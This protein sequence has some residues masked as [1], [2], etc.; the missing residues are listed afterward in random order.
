MPKV[1]SHSPVLATLVRRTRGSKPQCVERAG[2]VHTCLQAEAAGL[3]G[4]F[5]NISP[6]DLLRQGF[7]LQLE[8]ADMSTQAANKPH[9]S[10]LTS[11]VLGPQ[12]LVA[13]PGLFV[14]EI[15]F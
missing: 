5:F 3:C 2:T 7:S 13:L 15:Y 8:L 14:Y 11:L 4:N 12:G 6:P 1:P 9:G 10:V